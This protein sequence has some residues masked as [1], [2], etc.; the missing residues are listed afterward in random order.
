MRQATCAADLRG[1]CTPFAAPQTA[2]AFAAFSPQGCTYA[3]HPPQFEADL[4]NFLLFRGPYAWLGYSWIGCA[5]MNFTAGLP[6][7]LSLDYGEPQGLCA[8]TAPGSGVFVREWSQATVQMDC[9]SWT[10]TITMKQ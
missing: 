2:A 8:E 5:E 6:P 10:P 7:S 3:A 9:N 1:L 4:A